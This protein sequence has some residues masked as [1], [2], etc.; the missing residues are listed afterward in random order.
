MFSDFV[1]KDDRVNAIYFLKTY[2][3]LFDHD[4]KL[5]IILKEVY[6]LCMFDEI[7]KIEL[8]ISNRISTKIRKFLN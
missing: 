6:R 2:Q 3:Q 8:V 5:R 1:D 7:E 4:D